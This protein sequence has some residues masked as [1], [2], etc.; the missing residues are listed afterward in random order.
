MTTQ[1]YPQTLTEPTAKLLDQLG[2]A[3]LSI[4]DNFYLSGGT[5][6]SLQIGHR[7]SEDL[8]FFSKDQFNPIDLQSQLLTL[9]ELESVEIAEG[10]LNTFI[11]GVKLQFLHYPYALL[12]ETIGWQNISLSSVPDIACTKIQTV[13]M[14]GSKKDLID[15]YFL[16]QEFSLEQLL[17]LLEK[18][19]A[20]I[21]YST[22]HILKSLVYFEDADGQP[23]PRMHQQVDWEG[24][25]RLM[26][27]TVKNYSISST[28]E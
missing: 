22:T 9:G 23:M 13:G 17:N 19:Y 21:N 15:L 3:K 20:G 18:K 4:L 24:V 2:Q 28:I 7:E 27:E 25:K 1:F 6:L 10:T 11:K 14:R 8:D 16:L 12:E 5:G 26:V